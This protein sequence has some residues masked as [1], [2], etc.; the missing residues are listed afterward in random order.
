M[1]FRNPNLTICGLA[2]PKNIIDVFGRTVTPDGVGGTEVIVFLR[3]YTLPDKSQ[4][5]DRDSS[6]ILTGMSESP[7]FSDYQPALLKQHPNAT[8]SEDQT[9]L[10]DFEIIK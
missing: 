8:I 9:P 5:T 4:Y 3:C 7:S 10:K 2:A 1:A 6:F